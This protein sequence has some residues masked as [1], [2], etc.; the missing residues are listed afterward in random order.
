MEG[1]LI[2]VEKR[3]GLSYGYFQGMVTASHDRFWPYTHDGRLQIKSGNEDDKRE[4]LRNKAVVFTK[5][6]DVYHPATYQD[7]CGH[8]IWA[9]DGGAFRG[10][11]LEYLK[12][13]DK[14][15]AKLTFFA[16]AN[17]GVRYFP[18]DDALEPPPPYRSAIGQ[19]DVPYELVSI[20]E[21]EGLWHGRGR[22][23]TFTDSGAFSGSHPRFAGRDKANPPWR[24][25]DKRFEGR[26]PVGIMAED[27]AR[28]AYTLFAG[29]SAEFILSYVSNP[30]VDDV[31]TNL[32]V[33]DSL[34][35]EG[36][37]DLSGLEV[38]QASQGPFNPPVGSIN[39]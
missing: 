14:V 30:Y 20:F 9:W 39:H 21:S 19:M 4:K 23:E 10:E 36:V 24:W 18:S 27:P 3:T 13:S 17:Q 12:T 11:Y 7:P 6:D 33:V 37:L 8:G 15:V 31:S 26:L 29:F 35:G 1:C 16:N 28:L 38:D 34:V 22:P 2:I 25:K 32:E 5:L